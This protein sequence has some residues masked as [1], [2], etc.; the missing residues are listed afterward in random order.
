MTRTRT[1]AWEWVTTEQERL[2]GSPHALGVVVG[3]GEWHYDS[4]SLL[5]HFR[6]LWV[7]NYMIWPPAARTLGK[8]L[9]YSTTGVSGGSLIHSYTNTH[10][11]NIQSKNSGHIY[12]TKWARSF[13][14][15]QFD[16]NCNSFLVTGALV[17]LAVPL[18]S[19]PVARRGARDKYMTIMSG[20]WTRHSGMR[21]RTSF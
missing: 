12:K 3:G 6:I 5:F 10:F 7:M 1:A 14:R 20:K 17:A 16:S 9:I 2:N 11:K 21:S 8:S 13:M 4:N 15:I 18:G 19:L